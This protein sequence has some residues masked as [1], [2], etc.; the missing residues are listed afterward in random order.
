MEWISKG[1]YNDENMP[2]IDTIRAIAM[3]VWVSPS[4]DISPAFEKIG[5]INSGKIGHFARP[6]DG[7]DIDIYTS[8]DNEE[9]WQKVE[10]G[11]IE[12]ADRL[13]DYPYI[14]LRVIVKSYVSQIYPEKSPKLFSITIILSDKEYKEWSAD[15][16]LQLEWGDN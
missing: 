5:V 8:L 15:I 13:N 11:F 4:F 6:I 9:S 16:P 12:N 1:V 3:G 10:D 7:T 2:D 14:K